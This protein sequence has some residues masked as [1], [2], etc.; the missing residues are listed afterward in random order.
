MRILCALQGKYGERIAKNLGQH[1]PGDWQLTV[2]KAPPD[3]PLLVE[4]PEKHLPQS[5]PQVDLLLLVP[6]DTRL[7]ELGP[8]LAVATGAQALLA[9]RSNSTHI[10]PGL[11]RQLQV[12]LKENNIDYCFPMP[13]CSL[14][15]TYSNNE[16][17]RQ[18]ANFFG[19][20]R[21]LLQS[22]QDKVVGI[23]IQCETPCGCTR[24]VA[25]NLI[26]TSVQEAEAQAALYHH[27]YPCWASAQPIRALGDS[28]IHLAAKITRH[29]V[30][31]AVHGALAL[32]QDP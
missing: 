15:R 20:P 23:T 3:L 6:E 30:S 21:L 25:E 18:F 4:H 19:R 29:S 12:V 8:S 7:A 16:T 2:W 32:R 24:F 27:Y 26:G 17:I 1:M 11:M 5:L 31:K 9:P 10:P 14:T 28:L 13:F 22:S